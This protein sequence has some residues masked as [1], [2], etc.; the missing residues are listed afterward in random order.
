ML[1]VIGNLEA[2]TGSTTGYV[3]ITLGG[4]GNNVPRV[5]GTGVI[6]QSSV[7]SALGS[8]FSL[9]VFGNDTITPA[10]TFYVVTYQDSVGNVLAQ[11]NYSFTGVGTVDLA[12]LAPVSV[13]SGSTVSGVVL[14]RV[15]TTGDYNDLINAPLGGSGGAPQVNSDWNAITGVAQIL[16][17]PNLATVATSGSY[18]D[19]LNKPTIA[20]Q[21]NADWTAVSGVT[22]ILHKPVLAT[23]A[24]SG[25]YN[26]LINKPVTGVSSVAGRTGAITL[27]E[28]DIS[29]L[30]ADLGARELT[31]NKGVAS[32]YAP[33]DATGKVPLANL[34]A[35]SATWGSIVG[36]LSNQTDLQNALNL[37]APLASPTFT[38][39]VTATSIN[40]AGYQQAGAALNF[41]HL[42][43]TIAAAQLIPPTATTLGAVKSKAATTSNFLTGIGTDGS[44]TAAQAAF[45]DITG[46]ATAAQLPVFVGSGASHA[47][48]LVPDAGA[49]AGT[50]RF[51]RED[52]TWVAV[53]AAGTVSSVALSLPSLFT[54]SG[55]PVTTTGTLTAALA[56][57]TAQTVWAGPVVGSAAAA[58]TFRQLTGSDI[59]ARTNVQVIADS[60]TLTL[61]QTDWGKLIPVTPGLASTL[62]LPAPS[63]DG[64]WVRIQNIGTQNL[65]VNANTGQTIDGQSTVTLAPNAGL[66]IQ[67][68][69]TGGAYYSQRGT[70]S[71]VTSVALSLPSIFTVTG[72]PVTTS[73]TLTATLASQTANKILASPSGS[74]GTPSF[75]SLTTAD[76]PV[77]TAGITYVIDGGGGPPAAGAR[78]PLYIPAGCTI[79]GWAIALDQTDTVTVDVEHSTFASSPTFSSITGTGTPATSAVQAARN[80][81]ITGWTSTALSQ[82]DL[83][84]FHITTASTVAT[85][86]S[87][88]LLIT[89]P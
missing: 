55:S 26:D 58:P 77:R 68:F 2:L 15:A 85:L 81:A 40:S 18:T 37:K 82:G 36:T 45:S 73:G 41:S 29:G 75:R 88:T 22:Q 66:F 71:G 89:I 24:T 28:A 83:I 42:A 49:T 65:T 56:T 4:Y 48:G 19:L 21:L 9:S 59:V 1:T 64:W 30:V 13:V 7:T 54:V 6:I 57:Q 23:V 67:A 69:G 78:A 14:A 50:T 31:A 33:L 86:V 74:T 61:T 20:A 17:K 87:I 5:A 51:L 8:S 47:V 53:T 84:R 43:G 72:S 44:V 79:T 39:I 60:G 35:V 11:A 25:D 16:N 80:T 63:I 76:L 27:S 12:N 38:G 10:G 52:G 46:V 34:P 32:G 3:T 62:Q 70:G